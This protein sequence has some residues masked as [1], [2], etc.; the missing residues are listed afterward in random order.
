M[1]DKDTKRAL[2]L[3]EGKEFGFQK[4]ALLLDILTDAGFHVSS[5]CGGKGVCGKCLVGASGGLSERTPAEK[6]FTA[7]A[8][9]R[10]ACQAAGL[11]DIT[12]TV[13][14]PKPEEYRRGFTPDPGSR[15]GL[16]V[17]IGTTT[18]KASLIDLNGGTSF[19]VS[20]SLNPQRRFGH[21]VITR[22]SS[23]AD[24]QI[25]TKLV[26]LLRGE[27]AGIVER[28]RDLTGDRLASLAFSGNTVMTCY[29]MG[30]DV[31][32]MGTY[33]YTAPRT[34]FS[35]AGAEDLGIR[36]P[37]S[38]GRITVNPSASSFLGGDLVGGLA[39]LDSMGIRENLFFIDLG[40]NG[41]M[42][43][44]TGGSGISA[45]SC[46]MGP[47]LEGMNISAGMSA[48]EGAITHVALTD[49]GE[50]QLEVMG[51][52]PPL[53]ISGTAVI[54]L[55]ALLLR[56]GVVDPTGLLVRQEAEQAALSIGGL[57][58]DGGGKR[59]LLG[60]TVP[61]TQKDIRSVQLSK[62]A[63]FSAAS[64]LLEISG[65]RRE[66]V[67]VVAISGAFGEHLDI[68]NFRALGFIP[69]FPNAEYLFLGNTS[70]KSAEK[71]CADDAFAGAMSSLRDSVKTIELNSLEGFNDRFIDSINF[72]SP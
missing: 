43:I 23:S 50:I 62:A 14:S 48:A 22:I 4:D 38:I 30:L 27:I 42:F 7:G 65:T 5:P 37:G 11:D 6:K 15:Y 40:T 20:T 29:L 69:D 54:D 55:I 56:R 45:A 16:A 1:P 51:G 9:M 58:W 26:D 10:L 17:D 49:G 71:A 60:K 44:R 21:D 24:P 41:E 59:L 53:G 64:A 19:P 33:P 28:A 8:D 66:S 72:P 2:I 32:S 35:R 52:A 34:D 31:S 18:I 13:P 12:L 67:A 25:H 57:G 47:A 61:F 70:L 39:L 3:P 63:S 68:A 36:L 46:A